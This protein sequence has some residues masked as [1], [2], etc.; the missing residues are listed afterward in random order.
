MIAGWWQTDPRLLPKVQ[1][2]GCALLDSCY[3][4]P[5]DFQPSD[6]NE[7]YKTLLQVGFIDEDCL[8]LSWANVLNSISANLHFKTKTIE[9]YVCLANEREILKWWLSN[10]QENHFTVGNGSSMTAW[11]SMDRPDIMKEYA[12]FAEKI[13]VRI[14]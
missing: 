7:M 2:F 3:L 11:D 14:A 1:T 10:L 6:V 9:S 5:I 13:I 12:T 4:S 8:I